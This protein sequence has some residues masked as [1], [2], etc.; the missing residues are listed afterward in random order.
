MRKILKRTI[1]LTYSSRES[2]KKS[3]KKLKNSFERKWK[4]LRWLLVER[5]ESEKLKLNGS[6]F[7]YT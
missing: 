3:K 1:Q 2:L 7:I 6:S 4:K 5:L